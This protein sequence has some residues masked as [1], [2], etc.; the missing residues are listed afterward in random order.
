[1][2][3]PAGAATCQHSSLVQHQ[4]SLTIESYVPGSKRQ[5]LLMPREL[6]H[7]Q[8][9]GKHA[10]TKNITHPASLNTNT[11]IQPTAQHR[12]LGLGSSSLPH[13]PL[14]ACP[15]GGGAARS[16]QRQWTAVKPG[17]RGADVSCN[18]LPFFLDLSL[19]FAPGMEFFDAV[20]SSVDSEVVFQATLQVQCYGV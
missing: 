17:R 20:K 4:N 5:Q 15:R 14:A 12:P 8:H 6:S 7:A 10:L 13:Q 3:Q 16:L 19:A 2:T 11:N 1:M 9:P 18:V